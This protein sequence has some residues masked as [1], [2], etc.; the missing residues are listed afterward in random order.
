MYI[1]WDLLFNSYWSW[2]TFRF[3]S[4][5]NY[6]KD[7]AAFDVLTHTFKYSLSNIV[8]WESFIVKTHY[9]K[10]DWKDNKYRL[11]LFQKKKHEFLKQNLTI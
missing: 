11:Y 10:G 1:V 9:L 7:L 2:V 4:T 6:K 5:F 8:M 3:T